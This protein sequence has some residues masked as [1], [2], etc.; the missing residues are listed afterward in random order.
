MGHTTP[1][2]DDAKMLRIMAAGWC[3]WTGEPMRFSSAG[4]LIA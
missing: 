2:D 4:D 1:S 3:D